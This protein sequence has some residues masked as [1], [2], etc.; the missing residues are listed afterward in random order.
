MLVREIGR[1]G[2]GRVYQ[3]I[4]ADGEFHQA[5]AIKLIKRGMI[6]NSILRR[7]RQERDILSRLDHPNIARLLD[8]GTTEDGQP[9]LVMDYVDGIAITAYCFANRLTTRERL[10]LFASVCDA[11]HDAHKHSVVHRDL[12]P[13]NILV[14]KE[15]RP[16][17]LDFGVAKWMDPDLAP[18]TAAETLPGTRLLTPEYASPEQV[19]GEAVTERTDIYA[20][21]TILFELLSEAKAHQMTGRSLPELMV[22][23]CDSPTRKPSAEVQSTTARK[24]L[25]GDLDK[26]VMKAMHKDPRRRYESVE[27][28]GSDI[29]AYL[30][31]AAVSARGDNAFYRMRKA[32]W[33][34]RL[35]AGAMI[36]A[37]TALGAVGALLWERQAKEEKINSLAVLPF[38]NLGVQSREDTLADGL[39][40]D[41]ITELA[42]AP[43]LK[44]PGRTA[45]QRFKGKAV[46]V[47]DAGRQLG[48]NAVLEG[49]VRRTGGQVRIVAQL[50]S[51]R[52]GFHL[53]AESYDRQATDPLLLEREISRRIADDLKVRVSGNTAW[54]K[55]GRT[56]PASEASKD[57]LEGHRL[58]RGEDI[59]ASW[60]HGMPPRMQAAIDAFESATIKDPQFAAAWASLA[61]ASEWAIGFDESRRAQLRRTAEA[62]A[63]KALELEPTNAVASGT[64]GLIYWY[65]DWDLRRAEPL[66]RTAVEVNPRSSTQLSYF[67]DFL[68]VQ[69][70]L[71]EAKELLQ[72][73]QLL[74]PSTPRLPGRMAVILAQTG[75]CGEARSAGQRSLSLDPSFRNAQWAIALCDEFEG[76]EAEAERG[77]RALAKFSGGE[78][79]SQSAL[80]HL[81]AKSGQPAKV[82]EARRILASLL[83]LRAK[84]RRIEV[85]AALVHTGLGRKDDGRGSARRRM[86]A[87][88]STD[89][90]GDGR[91]A[92]Q[93]VG[94]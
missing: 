92:L 47:R 32:L 90:V 41:L 24:E 85:H 7:F 64:L 16:K 93:G 94:G 83:E 9:Y 81:L 43:G 42:S 22:A 87:S 4:R 54:K 8:A 86:G 3:A 56:A 49:S 79:R 10:D 58:F 31:G 15:R 55:S 68:A 17:L 84:N 78:T 45:V 27:E 40:E 25:E 46:D 82:A 53:W 35:T 36:L 71:I 51:V 29:R 66:L 2:M 89:V 50:I 18:E 61:D 21:G 30:A 74:E 20:L 76:K 57:Y 38:V 33:R 67:A 28:F 19:R 39:T 73:A 59:Q 48:V 37:V 60:T 77:Y 23:I 80:G 13:A 70:R 69:G 52:D 75:A 6:S 88:R 91:Q 34:N 1:G 12:K 44:V 11:V 62:A 72:R 26:I 65:Q 5:V 63:K 14:T